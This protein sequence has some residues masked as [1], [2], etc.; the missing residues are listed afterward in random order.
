MMDVPIERMNC[1]NCI[2][3]KDECFKVW[4]RT[5]K[6]KSVEL[7]RVKT[8]TFPFFENISH[9]LRSFTHWHCLYINKHLSRKH[10]TNNYTNKWANKQ[11]SKF[12]RF[13]LWKILIIY[14]HKFLKFQVYSNFINCTLIFYQFFLKQSYV[15]I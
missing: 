12:K 9:H 13:I 10:P 1:F 2:M 4:R 14:Y 11:I 6:R 7:I 8:M 15:D 5:N 3:A